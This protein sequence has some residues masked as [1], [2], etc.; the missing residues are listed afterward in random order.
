[1]SFRPCWVEIST[2]V[3]ED[4]FRLLQSLAPTEAELLAIVKGDAYGH[5]AAICAPA[6]AA[7][8]AKWL[9]VTSVEEGVAVRA[10]CPDARILVIGGV[11]TGQCKSVLT[12]NLTPSIWEHWQFDELE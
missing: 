5:S 2:R 4:N 7:A 6:L 12:N 9:G 10:L 8:G 3:L 11:F 1:M